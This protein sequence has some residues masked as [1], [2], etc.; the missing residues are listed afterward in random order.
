[1]TRDER[2]VS[3]LSLSIAL[4]LTG[5]PSEGLM[6][7]SYLPAAAQSWSGPAHAA[8]GSALRIGNEV[9]PLFG[10][11]APSSPQHC[12]SGPGEYYNCGRASTQALEDAVAGRIVQCSYVGAAR[13]A[14]IC[15]VDGRDVAELMVRA[16]RAVVSGAG[17]GP[18]AAAETDARSHRRGLWAGSFVNPEEWRRQ[19]GRSSPIIAIPER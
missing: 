14:A 13:A 2:V 10:I 12:A 1:L 3:F 18:Y 17:A 9:V 8:N 5:Q 6:A 15:T 16:G 7:I 19:F 4:T 11:D